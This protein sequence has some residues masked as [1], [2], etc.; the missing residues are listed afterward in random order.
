MDRQIFLARHGKTAGPFNDSQIQEMTDNGELYRYEWIWDGESPDWKPVPRKAKAPPPRPE[1]T[2]TKI[3]SPADIEE[4]IAPLKTSA[5]ATKATK[6]K[7]TPALD[8][9]KYSAILY[10]HEKAFAGKVSKTSDKSAI[11]LT[12]SPHH[13]FKMGQVIWVDLL[14]EEKDLAYKIRGAI[15][16]IQHSSNGWEMT[17]RLDQFPF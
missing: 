17:I 13:P 16:A 2:I 10:D 3:E 1:V 7:P 11:F 15:E 8:S 4:D 9:K 5:A 12:A 6:S 14:V